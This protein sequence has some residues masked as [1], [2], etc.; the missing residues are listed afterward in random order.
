M[1]FYL[2]F[3]NISF[4]FFNMAFIAQGIVYIPV[5]VPAQNPSQDT[6]ATQTDGLRK[7]INAN[8]RQTTII[9]HIQHQYPWLQW[10]LLTWEQKTII[11]ISRTK[12]DIPPQ[13]ATG[14]PV[15]VALLTIN[16][17]MINFHV[18][19]EI[20]SSEC[21]ENALGELSFD[22]IDRYLSM[23]ADS[24]VFCSG[25]KKS[26][27]KSVCSGISYEP[28]CFL[29]KHYPFERY[30]SRKCKKWYKLRINATKIDRQ[31]ASLG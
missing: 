9:H 15:T 10:R 17:E 13:Y 28:K 22:T 4:A 11:E 8:S 27:F 16:D 26:E 31:A 2:D 7:T 23:L 19:N 24:F 3:I 20:Q 25:I 18:A 21:I 6:K 5:M 12:V 29:L 30:I 14:A 1:Q